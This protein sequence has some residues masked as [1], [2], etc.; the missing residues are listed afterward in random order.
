MCC[1]RKFRW[2]YLLE[3]IIKYVLVLA[4][5]GSISCLLK[6]TNFHE[7]S[8]L[9]YCITRQRQA[10]LNPCRNI[11]YVKY[12]ICTNIQN[13]KLPGHCYPSSL[14]LQIQKFLLKMELLKIK[15]RNNILSVLLYLSTA[16]SC[17]ILS[18][19]KA[20]DYNQLLTQRFL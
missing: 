3:H 6:K 13:H 2:V 15:F 4:V 20:A 5:L 8:K 18:P 16:K 1:V 12:I 11:R 19:V 9:L 7:F 17:C 10:F 14:S